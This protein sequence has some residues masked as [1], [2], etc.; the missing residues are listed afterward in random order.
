MAYLDQLR[1]AADV[2]LASN[3]LAGVNNLYSV[4][5][6]VTTNTVRV[7]YGDGDQETVTDLFYKISNVKIVPS[8]LIG[9]KPWAKVLNND[10]VIDCSLVLPRQYI[11][12][13]ETTARGYDISQFTTVYGSTSIRTTTNPIDNYVTVTDY[14]IVGYS[15]SLTQIKLDLKQRN[16]LTRLFGD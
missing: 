5:L 6:V 11:Y 14:D 12:L 13:N 1:L 9:L 4:Q 10:V 8:L 15:Q 2:T 16:I 3:S 7:G